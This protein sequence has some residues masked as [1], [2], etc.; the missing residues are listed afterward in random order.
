MGWICG[1]KN[2]ILPFRIVFKSKS[3]KGKDIKKMG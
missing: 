2:K 3:M 1:G